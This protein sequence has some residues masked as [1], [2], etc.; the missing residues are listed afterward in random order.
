MSLVRSNE[1]GEI[2]FLAEQRRLNVAVTRAR[3]QVA[4]ICDTETVCSNQFIRYVFLLFSGLRYVRKGDFYN[5][6]A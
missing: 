5:K 2:G 4:I 1:H 3:R 6:A